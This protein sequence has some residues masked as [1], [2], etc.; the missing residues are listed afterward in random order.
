MISRAQIYNFLGTMGFSFRKILMGE[1]AIAKMEDLNNRRDIY[2][3]CE[4]KTG[5]KYFGCTSCNCYINTKTIFT[6]SEC[7]EGKWKT[8]DY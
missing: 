8:L 3:S 1:N 6:I 2:F 5:K 7:P 4:F